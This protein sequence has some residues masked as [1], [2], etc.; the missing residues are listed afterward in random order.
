MQFSDSIVHTTVSL[1][2]VFYD[3]TSSAPLN[4]TLTIGFTSLWLH[5][6]QA[7]HWIHHF[8]VFH[9]KRITAGQKSSKNTETFSS[10]HFGYHCV[11]HWTKKIMSE[12]LKTYP[13]I[14]S[15]QSYLWPMLHCY[16]FLLPISA[17]YSV[18]TSVHAQKIPVLLQKSHFSGKY[19]LL[20]VVSLLSLS[21]RSKA[22]IYM[23]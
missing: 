5:K 12:A 3:I 17:R 18:Q 8:I 20:K 4:E 10:H 13:T 9:I 23:K 19:I 22:F 16:Q 14:L 11:T 21:Q 2:A 6:S 1:M 15:S 7:G